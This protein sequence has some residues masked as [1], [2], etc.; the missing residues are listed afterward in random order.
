MTLGVLLK[1]TIA[2]T[3]VQPLGRVLLYAYN[4]CAMFLINAAASPKH[5]YKEK[6]GSSGAHVKRDAVVVSLST[7]CQSIN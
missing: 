3:V 7:G 6:C 5:R 2:S 4:V 1:D